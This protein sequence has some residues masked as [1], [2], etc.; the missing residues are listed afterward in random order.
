MFNNLID[1][2]DDDSEYDLE[3]FYL[4]ENFSYYLALESKKICNIFF[5]KK[6][7]FYNVPIFGMVHAYFV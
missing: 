2:T 6:G 5:I 1:E 3:M 7:Y 4:L